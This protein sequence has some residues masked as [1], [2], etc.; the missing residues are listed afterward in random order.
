[1]PILPLFLNTFSLGKIFQVERIFLLNFKDITPQTSLFLDSDGK[2]AHIFVVSAMLLLSVHCNHVTCD[3]I[4]SLVLVSLRFIEFL[5]HVGF[6]FST[7]V[8]YFGP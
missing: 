7:K 4:L 6:Q 3:N 8:E 5:V 2:S 1:M